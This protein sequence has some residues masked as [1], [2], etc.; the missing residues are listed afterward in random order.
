M[1]KAWACRQAG[2]AGKVR[3]MEWAQVGKA[4]MMGGE[5][6]GLKGKDGRRHAG[7]GDDGCRCI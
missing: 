2:S 7:G 3:Y 4:V 1:D 5:D 6:G